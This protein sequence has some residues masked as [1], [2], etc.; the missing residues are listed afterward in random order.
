MLD[1]GRYAAAETLA[2]EGRQQIAASQGEESLAAAEAA[3]LQVEALVRGGKAVAPASVLLAEKTISLKQRHGHRADATMA[4][5]LH[6]LGL[7]RVERG[8][9][10]AARV[11]LQRAL[12][13]RRAS[14]TLQPGDV[15]DTLDQLALTAIRAE[16]LAE[17][18]RRLRESLDL[19]HAAGSDAAR[20]R[21]LYLLALLHRQRGNYA[22]AVDTL[23]QAHTAQQTLR[24]DHP[25]RALI[26]ELSGDLSML[27]GQAAAAQQAWTEAAARV[28][29]SLGP[30][31]PSLARLHRVRGLAA[32]W[33]GA[34]DEARALFTTAAAIGEQGLAECHEEYGALLGSSALMA[35]ADGDY[36]AARRLQSR[37]LAIHER[38]LGPTHSMTVTAIHNLADVALQTGDLA[39]A[40]RMNTRAVRLWSLGL[41]PQHPYV[42]RGLD[43]LAEVVALRG[44]QQRARDLYARALSIRRRTL[45]GD[46]PDVAWT[47]MNLARTNA[48]AGNPSA[49]LSQINRAI[50][51]Y[52]RGGA[53]QTPDYFARALLFRGEI[54]MRRSGYD[55]ARESFR[56]AFD[57]R[58]RTFG[59]HHPLTA[60][61]RAGMAAAELAL[62]SGAD[63]L[64]LALQAE[65]DGRNHLRETIRYL[66]ERQAVGY[67]AIRPRGLDLAVSAVLDRDDRASAV[68][69]AV[70][71][72]RGVVLDE[73]AARTQSES[74]AESAFASLGAAAAS[75]RQRFANL[76][77]RL[78]RGDDSVSPA[79]IEAAQRRKEEAERELAEQSVAARGDLTRSAIGL[80]D[81]RRALPPSTALVSFIRHERLARTVTRNGTAVRR[82]AFYSAFVLRSDTG[83][84]R[85]LPLGSATA[86]EALIDAWRAEAS[87]HSTKP[88]AG[89][90]AAEQSYRSV[91]GALRA[92]V[93]D[94]LSS[95]VR[96]TS[97]VL[98]VPDGMV[99]LVAFA[100]LPVDRGRY[101]VESGQTVHYL[102]T[103]RDLVPRDSMPRGRGLLAV[104]GAPFDQ[105]PSISTAISA[106][107][108]GC[109][110][111]ESL[112]RFEPLP[113]ALEE[114]QDVARVWSSAASAVSGVND[115]VSGDAV[116]LSGSSATER[117]VTASMK[118]R[119]IVHLATHGFFLDTHCAAA[120]RAGGM[121]ANLVG[122]ILTA[123]NP[124]LLSGLALGQAK[125]GASDQTDDGILTAEEVTGLSLRGTEWVVLSACDTGV[126]TIRDGEG[127]FGLRRAFHVAGART[128]IMSLWSVED[129]ATRS[130]MRALYDARL[131]RGETTDRAVADASLSMLRERR[132][133]G[134]STHPFYWAAFVAA[135]DW[136]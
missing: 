112:L 27:D 34:L 98:I 43:A 74:Q 9:L 80:D 54:E 101:L 35:V 57:V 33:D 126:G 104:A 6:N 87:G 128:V 62:G 89:P 76:N 45:G 64:T 109:D 15:A 12:T 3:D 59:T 82:M 99:N 55:A 114:A 124:L 97:K 122:A 23:A 90:V 38:C 71:R 17:A 46:H 11:A 37:A 63:A 96:G 48:A 18:E 20:S 5:S 129:R 19:R 42:A 30:N 123:D 67:A 53:S 125:S 131:T 120:L 50:G 1:D 47:L 117:A 86:I 134:Q 107:R 58:E 26:V 127:V 40:E 61:A 88:V 24:P 94:P 136:Q 135:G 28:E 69:D 133:R 108:S 84:V 73:V 66:P 56:R 25:D 44:Q 31:H 93:W 16:R 81:V 116:V 95:W 102:S 60:E 79:A 118:G 41:G 52:E 39:E 85:V 77:Y 2:A 78:L 132:A 72:S 130:W 119:Q 75:A 4:V 110:R 103:E 36:P 70:I 100:A 22:Q 83:V 68:L 91:A 49:A 32:L 21:T 121:S 8:E 29:Q 13:I 105:R 106:R 10:A 7:L 92:K 65:E 51:I 14:A 113:M 115:H 111:P